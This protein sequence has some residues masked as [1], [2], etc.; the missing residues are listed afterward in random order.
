VPDYRES[1]VGGGW[2][3]EIEGPQ[4]KARRVGPER[5]RTPSQSSLI[6]EIIKL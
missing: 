3:L 2:H 6:A 5:Q 4:W 1:G